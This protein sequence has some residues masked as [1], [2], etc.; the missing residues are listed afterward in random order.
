[1]VKSGDLTKRMLAAIKKP[2]QGRDLGGR[3]RN[4]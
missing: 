1:M 2:F 4:K 3:G